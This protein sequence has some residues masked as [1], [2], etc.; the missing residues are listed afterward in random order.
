MITPQT[1]G[2]ASH[3]TGTFRSYSHM[4][5]LALYLSLH[6]TSH[7]TS[8]IMERPPSPKKL[9]RPKTARSHSNTENMSAP[10]RSQ[11]AL[12]QALPNLH[13]HPRH[14]NNDKHKRHAERHPIAHAAVQ[15][16]VNVTSA[17]AEKFG[18][19]RN[20]STTAFTPRNSNPKVD[21]KQAAPLK[22]PPQLAKPIDVAKQ[23]HRRVRRDDELRVT[24]DS[25][26][27]L[28]SNNTR[29]VDMLIIGLKEKVGT[30]QSTIQKLQE[31][32]TE[33]AR[34]RKEF[35]HEATDIETEYSGQ[36]EGFKGFNEQRHAVETL[37]G[38]IENSVNRS[39]RLQD[40]LK[41]ARDRVA[42]W[43]KREDEWQA[44]TS[45]KLKIG[46]V[47]FGVLVVFLLL[48]LLIHALYVRTSTP[49]IVAKA[50]VNTTD[51]EWLWKRPSGG[52]RTANNVT[53]ITTGIDVRLRLLDEL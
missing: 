37:R 41:M 53:Y 48:G 4:L 3:F 38:R 32:A 26:T 21:E 34:M 8:I 47:C 17:L 46:W 50:L 35:E 49:P 45:L 43:E 19:S 30:L 33:S 9:V 16:P 52:L 14:H 7:G 44:K 24:L 10:H 12:R 40:R 29:K 13:L 36:V 28:A 2:F 23:R 42:E 11:T 25:L 51:L 20:T 31:L 22:A 27:D 15:V 39:Q 1:R 5:H 6:S 18:S